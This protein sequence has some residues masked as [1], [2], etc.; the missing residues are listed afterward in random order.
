M[1]KKCFYKTLGNTLA[2]WMV[3]P[4]N[5][6]LF[7]WETHYVERMKSIN[8]YEFRSVSFFDMPIVDRFIY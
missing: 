1:T 2:R 6:Y 8:L 5:F 4:K 3:T 7:R